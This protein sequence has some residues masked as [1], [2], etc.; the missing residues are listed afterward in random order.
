MSTTE[1]QARAAVRAQLPDSAVSFPIYWQGDDAPTLPDTP[2]A[3]AFI[4]FNNEG[5]GG[6]PAAFG[7]GAGNNLYRNRALVEA[8]VF[9]PRSSEPGASV[10]SG[11]AEQIAARLRSFRDSDISVMAADVIYIG[12]GSSISLPGLDAVENYNCAV[13]E[14]S[15]HFD[16]IG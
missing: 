3:F 8:F 1:S 12:P 6:S 13:A 9:T 2:A 5:S 15:L 16:Q 14:I 10:A 4:V 7:G 11:R